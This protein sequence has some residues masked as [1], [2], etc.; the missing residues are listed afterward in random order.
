M[1]PSAIPSKSEPWPVYNCQ[2]LKF[3]EKL[4]SSFDGVCVVPSNEAT[5][6]GSR[7][8]FLCLLGWDAVNRLIS[9][10]GRI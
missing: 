10:C 7:S 4:I 6:Q 2:G 5:Y 3:K 1:S 8:Q 9:D